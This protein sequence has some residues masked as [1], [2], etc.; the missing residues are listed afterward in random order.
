MS[1]NDYSQKKFGFWDEL[2]R[3]ERRR[4]DSLSEELIQKLWIEGLFQ[5]HTAKRYGIVIIKVSEIEMYSPDRLL[6]E[7][8]SR[9]FHVIEIGDQWVIICNKGDMRVIL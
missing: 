5:S 1:I 7:I 4:L 9:G 6:E 8:K 3:P 2:W